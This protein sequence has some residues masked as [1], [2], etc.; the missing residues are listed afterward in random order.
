MEVI[1]KYMHVAYAQGDKGETTLY[2][3]CYVDRWISVRV[4]ELIRSRHMC[5]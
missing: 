2:V 4:I 5:R 3:H 1:H